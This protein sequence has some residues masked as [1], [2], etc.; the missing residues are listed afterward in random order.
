VT[1]HEDDDIA[2]Y[3]AEYETNEEKEA[4]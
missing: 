4:A 3:R 1:F 2:A